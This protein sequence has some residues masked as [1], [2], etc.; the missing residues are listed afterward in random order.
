[1]FTFTVLLESANN[2]FCR[3]WWGTR[4]AERSASSAWCRYTRQPFTGAPPVWVC[5]GLWGGRGWHGAVRPGDAAMRVVP[6]SLFSG[7]TSLCDRARSQAPSHARGAGV[8]RLTLSAPLR[9]CPLRW[10]KGLH[11]LSPHG[12]LVG[13]G[14]QGPGQPVVPPRPRQRRDG[15]G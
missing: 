12:I 1:M 7:V 8:C 11:G 15:N 10:R 4:V 13:R 14:S 3:S 9:T 6:A 2:G 5:V